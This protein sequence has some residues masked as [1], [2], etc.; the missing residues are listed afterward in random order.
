MMRFSGHGTSIRSASK[1]LAIRVGIQ[2]ASHR[3]RVLHTTCQ[4]WFDSLLQNR[5]NHTAGTALSCFS[6]SVLTGVRMSAFS[7]A[8]FRSDAQSLHFYGTCSKPVRSWSMGPFVPQS[9]V[10]PSSIGQMKLSAVVN[11]AGAPQLQTFRPCARGSE[12]RSLVLA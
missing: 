2:F 5:S 12:L 10:R 8:Q 6:T 7:P 3:R 11:P 1:T 4:L 9:Y